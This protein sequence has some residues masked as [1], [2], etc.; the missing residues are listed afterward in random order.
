MVFEKSAIELYLK[1]IDKESLLSREEE[2][3]LLRRIK[4]RNDKNS[5]DK[6]IRGNLRFVVNVAKKYQNLGLPLID[7]IN[8]GNLG[9]I[10]AVKRFNPES[11]YHFIS[12]AV[13][14]I[15]QSILKALAEKY[16]EPI[17]AQDPPRKVHTVEPE[18]LGEKR[19]EVHKEVRAPN[20]MISWH[21]P[22]TSSTDY[23][24]LSL[25]DTILSD[26]RT[27]RLYKSLMNSTK[28]S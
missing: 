13:W 14:W 16:I 4:T 27:S 2:V 23:Y 20:L 12:Y 28:T 5:K 3:K 11:G 26:G 18:Q 9:L 10:T 1:D 25:L 7:L 19:I 24:A 6:L 21:V 17:P 22:A 8:E 15:R